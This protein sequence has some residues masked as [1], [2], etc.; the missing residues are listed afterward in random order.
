MIS[1]KENR[2]LPSKRLRTLL[3]ISLGKAT[4]GLSKEEKNKSKIKKMR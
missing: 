2:F 4:I 3:P 1:Q